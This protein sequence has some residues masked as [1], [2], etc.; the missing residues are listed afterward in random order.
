M[1]CSKKPNSDML[2]ED[3]YM[4]KTDKNGEINVDVKYLESSESD[5]EEKELARQRNEE[6]EAKAEEKGAI[7]EFQDACSDGNANS[8]KQCIAADDSRV[9]TLIF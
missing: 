6:A 7:A 1:A 3:E 8:V 2:S 5:L 4:R 9:E